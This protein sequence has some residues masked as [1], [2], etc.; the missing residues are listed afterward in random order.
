MA[1]FLP[2]VTKT[3]VHNGC[4]LKLIIFE[5][6]GQTLLNY[7]F[8]MGKNKN[9]ILNSQAPKQAGVAQNEQNA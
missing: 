2:G 9:Q 1:I 3:V 5:K 7:A 4:F 8:I 6:I